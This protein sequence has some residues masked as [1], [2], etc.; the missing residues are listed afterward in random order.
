MKDYDNFFFPVNDLEKAKDF[1]KNVL[2]LSTKFDFS[3]KG[4][5]AFK[6]G[7]QEPSIILKDINKFPDTK[8]TIWFVVDNV[9]EEYKKLKEKGVQ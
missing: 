8:A 5:V 3:D 6:A 1:Y 7:P 4:M 9:N 2:G